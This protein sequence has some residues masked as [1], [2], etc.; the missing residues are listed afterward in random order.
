M[1]DAWCRALNVVRQEELLEQTLTMLA[2]GVSNG[3]HEQ[4]R[5]QRIEELARKRT[6]VG[7]GVA[8]HHRKLP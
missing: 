7:S 2:N 3:D 4:R 1:V 6:G 8:Y 5:Q